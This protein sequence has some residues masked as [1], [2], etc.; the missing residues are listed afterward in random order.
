MKYDLSSIMNRA[1]SIKRADRRND[2]GLCL[3][4]AW[5]EAKEGKTMNGVSEKQI[6]YALDVQAR[7]IARL[8]KISHY[9]DNDPE[10]AAEVRKAVAHAMGI[11]NGYTEARD[12]L[13]KAEII[14]NETDGICR[15]F[16]PERGYGFEY[17]LS[18]KPMVYAYLSGAISTMTRLE[19]SRYHY[20]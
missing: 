3:R 14:V 17:L 18:K 20:I 9:W 2:F 11:I 1:W 13:D 5:E 15:G 12:V 6:N 8:E 10:Y 4:M 7:S 16:A 19:K